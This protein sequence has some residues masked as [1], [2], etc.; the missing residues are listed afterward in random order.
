MVLKRS[1]IDRVVLSVIG[2]L[3]A[4]ATIYECDRLMMKGP[5]N[6]KSDGL[7]IS[8]L[9]CFSALNNGRKL[10]STKTGSGNL[11]CIHGI[12]VLST[13]WVV[14]GHSFLFWVKIPGPNSFKAHEVIP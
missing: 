7:A 3:V 13:F 4:A 2:L 8:I 12:R 1:T 14:M 5:I 6:P 9:H 10:L 11:G